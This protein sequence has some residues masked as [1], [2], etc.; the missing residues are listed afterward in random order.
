MKRIFH[1]AC[2]TAR[3]CQ[4]ASGENFFLVINSIKQS[5]DAENGKCNEINENITE[6]QGVAQALARH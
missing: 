4:D 1:D 6:N 2:V 5:S 3:K